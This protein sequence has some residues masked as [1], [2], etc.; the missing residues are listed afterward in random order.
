MKTFFSVGSLLVGLVC[1]C[2]SWAA[3]MHLKLSDSS[4]ASQVVSC[5]DSRCVLSGLATGS[6]QVQVCDA[7]GRAVSS[8]AA[9][10]YSIVSPRDAASGLPT[11]KRTHRPLAVSKGL[12]KSSPQLF[13]LVI[14]E[15]GASVSI[16][17]VSATSEAP[18][19]TASGKVGGAGA[20]K[21]SLQDMSISR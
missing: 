18:G 13:S 15:A 11:G 20:G 5:P 1:S 3:D 7:Q 21:V 9:L 12:D 4:G 17:P 16:Q 8:S 14:P 19:A 2:G 6:Y 10:S